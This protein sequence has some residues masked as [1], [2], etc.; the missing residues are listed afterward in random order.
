MG[1][2]RKIWVT[3][4]V[5]LSLLTGTPLAADT[6]ANSGVQTQLVV[7]QSEVTSGLPIESDETG[8]QEPGVVV[9]EPPVA[10]LLLVGLGC[11][12]AIRRWWSDQ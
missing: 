6:L 11:L 12:I 3:V 1:T 7:A 2:L 8:V 10:L 9:N 5:C 4:T